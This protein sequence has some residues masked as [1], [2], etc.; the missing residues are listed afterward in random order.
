MAIDARNELMRAASD[1]YRKAAKKEKGQ[2]LD[3]V[4]ANSGLTRKHA[5]RLLRSP[6]QP[7]YFRSFFTSSSSSSIRVTLSSRSS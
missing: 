4:C 6:P 1:R 7:R 3:E 5:I 2:I